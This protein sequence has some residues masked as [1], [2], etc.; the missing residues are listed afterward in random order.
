MSGKAP[1]SK[2]D[3]AVSERE[4]SIENIPIAAY[5]SNLHSKPV[6]R[7]RIGKVTHNTQ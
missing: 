4:E 3:G 1:C 7:D 2:D 6:Y 5:G